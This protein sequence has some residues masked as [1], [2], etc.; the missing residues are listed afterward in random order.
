[1]NMLLLLLPLLLYYVGPFYYVVRK[2]RG[3]FGEQILPE[4]SL[5]WLSSHSQAKAVLLIMDLV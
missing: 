2:E 3:H 4:N 1:M 5:S